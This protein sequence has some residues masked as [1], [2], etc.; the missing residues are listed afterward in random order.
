MALVDVLGGIPH[1]LL[2]LYRGANAIIHSGMVSQGKM[3]GLRRQGFFV[4]M[5]EMLDTFNEHYYDKR[6]YD[7]RRPG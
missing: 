3:G 4:G 2:T 7:E 6:R 5:K 1:Q